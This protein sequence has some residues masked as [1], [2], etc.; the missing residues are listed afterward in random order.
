M[1]LLIVEDE[2]VVADLY[3]RL[4]RPYCRSI[5]V[6]HNVTELREYLGTFPDF[7]VV[8]FDLIT[9]PPA[10]AEIET[11]RQANPDSI[12]IIASGNRNPDVVTEAMAYG[13]D[14][15]AVKPETGTREGIIRAILEGAKKKESAGRIALIERLTAAIQSKSQTQKLQAS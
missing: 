9:G 1:K 11:I 10:I 4:L 12:I 13:A 8:L 15:Y 7:N 3:I 14:Y 2:Q 5:D 6:V